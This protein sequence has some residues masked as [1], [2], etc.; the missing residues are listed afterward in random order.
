MKLFYSTDFEGHWPVGAALIVVA[1]SYDDA[2]L[3][4]KELCAEFGCKWLDTSTLVEVSLLT[5]SGEM[6]V[7][8]EY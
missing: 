6:L 3:R 8:G 1:P 2:L 5:P 4:A 7:T